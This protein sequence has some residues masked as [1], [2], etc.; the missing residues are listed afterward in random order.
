LHATCVPIHAT[1][2]DDFLAEL[3]ASTALITGQHTDDR[4]TNYAVLE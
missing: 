1:T 2:V 4:T 3:R